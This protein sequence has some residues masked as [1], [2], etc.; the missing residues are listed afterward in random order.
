MLGGHNVFFLEAL[1]LL[2]LS[3]EP[4]RLDVGLCFLDLDSGIYLL[5]YVIL[6]IVIDS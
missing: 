2:K 4:L 3:I 5:L 6:A 1:G